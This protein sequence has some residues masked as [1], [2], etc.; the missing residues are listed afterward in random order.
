MTTNIL[1]TDSKTVI[2]KNERRVWELSAEL[3]ALAAL[4]RNMDTSD[5]NSD[6]FYGLSL[7]L[8][9]MSKRLKLVSE[10]LSMAVNK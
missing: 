7:S 9:R 5:I 6:E 4:F 2:C 10:E 3:S 8:V 1:C